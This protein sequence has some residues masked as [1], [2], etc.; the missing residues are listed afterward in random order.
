LL[1]LSLSADRGPLG[2]EWRALLDLQCL[3]ARLPARRSTRSNE[4][5]G[6][7]GVRQV[8][9]IPV[10]GKRDRDA[11][12]GRE[13]PM[14]PRVGILTTGFA[15]I[16]AA[17]IALPSWGGTPAPPAHTTPGGTASARARGV[18][19]DEDVIRSLRAIG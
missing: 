7:P 13:E 18:E 16:R 3:S 11:P 1:R 9:D 6:G 5:G 14:G 4:A 10:G 17:T 15:C 12:D 2:A 8:A 19:P